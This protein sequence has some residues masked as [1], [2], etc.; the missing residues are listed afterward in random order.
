[1][2]NGARFC[3]SCGSALPA[4][5]G[6]DEMLKLVSVLFADVVGSTARAET[7]Y[8][9]DV[10]ALMADFFA[11][12][13]EEILA[14]GGTIEK[15]VGD[16]IMA[17]FGVPTAHEDDAVR[18][19]RAGQRMLDRL[20]RWNQGRIEAERLELRVGVD[21][22]EVIASS[23]T[24]GGGLLVTGDAVNVAARLQQTAEPGTVVVGERTA[25]AVRSHFELRPVE[26]PLALKGKSQTVAAWIVQSAR[27]TEQPRGIPGLTAPLVG[28]DLQ[29]ASL[30]ATFERVRNAGRPEL[31]TVL[32]DAG[33][34]KSRL[35]REFMSALSDQI[36]V[37][38]GRCL[39]PGQGLT[40]GPLTEILHT[41]ADVLDTDAADVAFTK[42]ERL[43]AA[44]DAE[45]VPDQGRTSRA[46]AS[47][48]GL[49]PPGEVT[50]TPNPHDVYYELVTAWLALLG[51]WGRQG[52]VVA[53]VE[54]IHWADATMLDVLDELAE[55]LEGPVL[56][57]CTARPDL[58]RERPGWGGG[59]RGYSS[60]PLEPLGAE[61]SARL[62]SLLLD[63]D[64]L[65]E[66][67]RQR[68]LDRSE[69]NPFFLEEIIHHLIDDG[70][71]VQEGQ[72][73]RAGRGIEHVEIPDTVHA[74]ILARLDL[75]LRDEK[76]A[77]QRAAV[78]GRIFWDGAVSSLAEINDLEDCL[79]TLR[80]REFVVERLASSIARQR[81]FAFKHVLIR[82][83]CY[84][85]LPRRER[86]RVHVQTAAWIER[87]TADRTRERAELLAY[88]Y[89][90]AYSYLHDDDLRRQA[91]VQLLAAARNAEGQFAIS[92]GVRFA[93]R[94]VELSPSSGERVE[95]LEAL[96]DVHSVAFHGDAAWQVYGEAISELSEQDPAYARL[97][98]KA[99]AFGVRWVGA[100]RELPTI[101]E[102]RRLIDSGL[103]AAPS[104]GADRTLLL[105]HRGWLLIREGQLDAESEAA[106]REAT[107][108]AEDLDD[109]DLISE[110]L[111]LRQAQESASGHHGHAYR[112]LLRRIELVPRLTNAREVADAYATAAI[113]AV[114]LGRFR[115]AE[116]FATAAV[117]RSRAVDP[118]SYLHG[119]AWRVCARF[120]LGDWKG[121]LADQSE[122]ER[123]AA[124]DAPELPAGFTMSAYGFAALCRELQVDTTGADHYIELG[125]NYFARRQR[126]VPASIH[127]APLALALAHRGRFEDALDLVP[128]VPHS[129]AAGR[130][131]EVRCEITGAQG[132]W[133]EAT[134]LIAAAREEARY[135]EQ[136]S[137]PLYADRLQGQAAAA[138][139]DVALSLEMLT[140]SAD[141]FAAL[142]AIWEEARSR[143]LLAEVV[144]QDDHQ[145]A[146][147]QIGLA[148]PVFERLGSVA[149][150]Q[151]TRAL[152]D[153][154]S[155]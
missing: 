106:T 89:D 96:G 79:R 128:L 40:F 113:E 64:A 80:R 95:A 20:R 136:L 30:T 104:A 15:F 152:L 5:V 154:L 6:S 146:K 114:H 44:V 73:W 49:R 11:S 94:A 68:V 31:V 17:V 127:T 137:L 27:E 28:R 107:K 100:I 135:G 133:Q 155:R 130:T 33:I 39:S 8:P 54:D 117:E 86:G 55:R 50:A 98:G 87:T 10:R 36:K 138:H 19:V 131:L 101:D 25:R 7:L 82:D 97:A 66:R 65:T 57:L 141:G 122:L 102:L 125:L 83:V 149:E 150:M 62:V 140:R 69:G 9:E 52:P 16:A 123:V 109:P 2:P 88:H 23:G 37:A 90:A 71:L 143:L 3:P 108:A 111:D 63:V 147:T 153:R 61:D 43:V 81:E 145:H 76:R 132:R 70:L 59:R 72:Q 91:R 139:N 58:L 110:A 26:R 67:L 47:T 115:R 144:S 13:S 42:I 18:A 93:Q 74:V 112:T 24:S 99:A 78:V 14:E 120:M 35:V 118:G 4:A 41:E 84:D 151:R 46:L 29:L 116:E 103:R 142:E 85:S 53:V 134:G 32:G 121:A 12:M 75:L 45:L 77:A 34:G 92:E 119:L 1:M 38:V 56:F 126:R 148:L 129:Q 22:G 51:S 124:Q 21:T 105:I 48:L 60:L